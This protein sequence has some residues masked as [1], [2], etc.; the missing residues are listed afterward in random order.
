MGRIKLP[1]YR[2]STAM[3]KAGTQDVKSNLSR[4]IA[5]VKA[6]E[7]FL[8]T[9]SGRP[10][11]G[12]V[13]EHRGNKRLRTAHRSLTEKDVVTLPNRRINWIRCL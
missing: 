7:E 11:A 12:I 8:I 4:Y 1:S 10:V 2:R 5:Q 9:D 3:M 13:K 6:G